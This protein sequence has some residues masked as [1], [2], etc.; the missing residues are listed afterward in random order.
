MLISWLRTLAFREV[1]EGVMIF[2]LAIK[3]CSRLVQNYKLV[4]FAVP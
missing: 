2:W 4:Q 3:S 1:L